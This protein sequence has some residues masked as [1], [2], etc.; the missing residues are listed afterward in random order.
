[1]HCRLTTTHTTDRSGAGQRAIGF[2]MAAAVLFALAGTALAAAPSDPP[3]SQA[4][5]DAWIQGCLETAFALNPHLGRFIIDTRVDQGKVMLSG[6]LDSNIDRDLVIEIASA[7]DGVTEVQSTLTVD[8]SALSAPAVIDREGDRSFA[9]WVKDATTTARI[10]SNLLANGNTQ[11]LTIDVAT[12][13]DVVT[14]S[15]NVDS[16]KN[17]LLAEMIAR[18]TEGITSVQ[19]QI[20]VPDQT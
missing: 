1:M 8:P 17:S 14:L 9:Q 20:K 19:N 12:H 2:G 11:G 10:K 6:T 3:P 16:R 5:R 4:V 7:V 15:G 18:N 13:H